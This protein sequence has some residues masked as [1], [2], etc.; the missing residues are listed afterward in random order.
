MIRASDGE[1]AVTEAPPGPECDRALAV[2]IGRLVPT[3]REK[4][5]SHPFGLC[6]G[7]SPS[8]VRSV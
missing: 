5:V 8:L 2:E 3:N 1:L 6:A 4:R 7:R